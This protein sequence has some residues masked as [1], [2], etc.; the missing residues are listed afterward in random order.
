MIGQINLNDCGRIIGSHIYLPLLFNSKC[1]LGHNM[2]Q[3]EIRRTEAIYPGQTYGILQGLAAT[4]D[5]LGLGLS[6]RSCAAEHGGTS[7]GAACRRR[8]G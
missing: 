4:K 8:I 2:P 6:A 5:K 1:R 7:G 3:Q